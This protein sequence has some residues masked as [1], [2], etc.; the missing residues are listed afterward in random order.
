MITTVGNRPQSSTGIG[1]DAR[2]AEPLPKAPAG[3]AT[4]SVPTHVS[5][6]AAQL[7][8]SAADAAAR[9]Q[10]GAETLAHRAERLL[11]QIL[12][13]GY[14]ARKQAA[15]NEVPTTQ[16][17]AL[18]ERARQATRFVHRGDG[19]E[20]NPF[21]GLSVEQLTTIAYDESGTF[22]TNERRAAY[23]ESYRLDQVWRRQFV[24]KMQDEYNRTGKVTESLKDLLAY[25]EELPDIERAQLPEH[26][27]EELQSRIAADFNYRDSGGGGMPSL[28]TMPAPFRH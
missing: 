23:L 6:L 15:D 19:E 27:T 2:A 13:A 28:P 9:R 4:P 25:V 14:E 10:S 12:G 7:A 24:A 1:T 21:A 17:P 8:A 26:Y 11:D 18:L 22:T 20:A 16:D 5:P 3:A